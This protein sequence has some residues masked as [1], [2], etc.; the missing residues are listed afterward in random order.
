MR[1]R[2]R[3]GFATEPPSAYLRAMSLL[4]R[5]FARR[6]DSRESVR[7]L[8]DAIV[9]RGR[10]PLWYRAGVPDTIDGRF[11]MIT[12]IL[13][14]VLLR[15]EGEDAARQESALLA[16]LFIEDMDAQLRQSGVGDVTVGKHI[17]KMLA[18]L[19]GRLTA[20]RE[21]GDDAEA[22]RAALV[23]NLWRGEPEAAEAGGAITV[24]ASL[25]Q[26][27]HALRARSTATIVAGQLPDIGG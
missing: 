13:A 1:G 6:P 22:M 15:L 11:D 17:G 4:T 27:V 10:L 21:A 14:Q 23:R 7:P 2:L 3:R 8:Y 12:A 16:E 18:A 9:A 20:Y 5:L 25:Q 19:G 26:F 24:T